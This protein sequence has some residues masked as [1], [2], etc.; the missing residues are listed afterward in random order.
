MQI[1]AQSIQQYNN[2]EQAQQ[3]VVDAEARAI[4]AALR[5][6]LDDGLLVMIDNTIHFRDII[7]E[8][9]MMEVDCV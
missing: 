9:S 2:I 6:L 1:H 5:T 3:D 7:K 4:V 8:K